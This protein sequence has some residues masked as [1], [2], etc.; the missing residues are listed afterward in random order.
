MGV[1]ECRRPGCDTILCQRYSE[2]FGY[3]CDDCFNEMKDKKMPVRLFM[4]S[5]KGAGWGA[6]DYDKEFS[7]NIPGDANE[8]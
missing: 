4:S 5:Y 2:E 6:C 8:N 7:L 1:M 3:I